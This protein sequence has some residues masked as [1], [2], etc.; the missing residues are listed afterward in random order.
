MAV[1]AM[2]GA[3]SEDKGGYNVVQV[4]TRTTLDIIGVAGI[5]IHLKSYR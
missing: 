5:P 2:E 4:L 1:L 3:T